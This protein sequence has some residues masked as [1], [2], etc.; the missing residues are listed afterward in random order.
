MSRL[1]QP[2]IKSKVIDIISDI[3]KEHRERLKSQHFKNLAKLREQAAAHGAGNVP[4]DI[5]NSIEAEEMA[6]NE[7]E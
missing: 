4:L 6:I 2:E 1:D 5:Q 3:D 7:L